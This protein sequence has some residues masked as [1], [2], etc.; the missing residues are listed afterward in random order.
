MPDIEYGPGQ[1]SRYSDSIRAERSCDQIPV[2]GEI[3]RTR[4]DRPETHPPSYTMGTGSFPGV[5][6]PRRG[7]DHPPLTSAEVK[8]RV[9]LYLYS[10]Y[11]PSWPDLAELYRILNGHLGTFTI[12]N[13]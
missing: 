5:E 13:L 2:G 10:H 4:T 12:I 1:L 11:K 3:F 7:V 9:G 6:R 8:E